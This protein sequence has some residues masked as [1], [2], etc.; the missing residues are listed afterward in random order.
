MPNQQHGLED[1]N[2]GKEASSWY[3][4]NQTFSISLQDEKYQGSTW[5]LSNPRHFMKGD[6]STV[7]IEVTRILK[8]KNRVK[9]RSVARG[10]G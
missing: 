2:R 3:T 5:M 4:Q 9:D 10:A 6:K 7:K 8:V 1:C